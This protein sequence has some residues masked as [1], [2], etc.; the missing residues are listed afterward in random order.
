MS[1]D[2][3]IFNFK[4]EPRCDSCMYLQLRLLA[5]AK[6]DATDNPHSASAREMERM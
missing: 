1:S 2:T 5:I 6:F 4:F 3:S